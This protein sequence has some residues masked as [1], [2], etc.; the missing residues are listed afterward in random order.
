MDP[1]TQ[2]LSFQP[3][4]FQEM[5]S[6]RESQRLMALIPLTRQRLSQQILQPPPME[7]ARLP[8]NQG[9][10]PTL[11][12]GRSGLHP[13]PNASYGIS[14]MG[15]VP[16]HHLQPP[17]T[18]MGGEPCTLAGMLNARGR[19]FASARNEA[20]DSEYQDHA[21][22][23]TPCLACCSGIVNVGQRAGEE[24]P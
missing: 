16:Q 12:S 24:E 15:L 8:G 9:F 10:I 23:S 22:S 5:Y 18:A 14:S 3:H 1:L 19:R 20:E 11:L 21:H 2:S 6:T 7:R 4:F 17:S 13:V